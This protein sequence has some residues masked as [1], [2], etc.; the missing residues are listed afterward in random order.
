LFLGHITPTNLRATAKVLVRQL[1]VESVVPQDATPC[2]AVAGDGLDAI[3]P[4][5]IHGRPRGPLHVVDFLRELGVDGITVILAY[6][7]HNLGCFVLPVV[8]AIDIEGQLHTLALDSV[9]GGYTE[10]EV[11]VLSFCGHVVPT[12]D[13]FARLEVVV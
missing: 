8:L 10:A 12:C 1:L 3:G 11:V 9:L 6:L 2:C 13:S 5:R 7:L 4:V